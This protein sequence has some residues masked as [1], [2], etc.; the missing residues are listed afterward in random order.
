MAS[1][2]VL[3]LMLICPKLNKANKKKHVAASIK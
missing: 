1:T 2:D 3:N